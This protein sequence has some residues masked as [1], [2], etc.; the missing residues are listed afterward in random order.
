MFD[1]L[2]SV[3]T[4][5]FRTYISRR[6]ARVGQQRLQRAKADRFSL[7]A[8]QQLALFRQE[9]ERS[10]QPDD[11]EPGVYQIPG[12]KGIW[13]G[14]GTFLGGALDL[15]ARPGQAVSGAVLGAQGREGF[16]TLEGIR[17][18]LFG[19]PEEREDLN[20]ATVLENEGVE[21][22][23]VR[24]IAGLA[25]DMIADPLNV[26]FA[27][28]IRRPFQSAVSA[29]GR[30]VRDAPV[31]V[32]RTVS[33]AFSQRIGGTTHY[34]LRGLVRRGLITQ[35][36]LNELED[37]ARR[38]R[39][40][41]SAQAQESAVTGAKAGIG[42]YTREEG[43]KALQTLMRGHG[44]GRV[45]DAIKAATSLGRPGEARV[46]A[47]FTRRF[48]G[49]KLSKESAERIEGE[50]RQRGE[51]VLERELE[52]LG[53]ASL[54]GLPEGDIARL[55][56]VY[57]NV[58][59][60]PG[61]Y[62]R[63]VWRQTATPQS[64]TALRNIRRTAEK[65]EV[66]KTKGPDL[67]KR[68]EDPEGGLVSDPVELA[69][70]DVYQTTL[71]AER[72]K[73]LRL[74]VN[75]AGS[76]FRKFERKAGAIGPDEGILEI[77]PQ[78]LIDGKELRKAGLAD[79]R[80]P[81]GAQLD[82]RLAKGRT[83]E[84]WV[85]P[86]EM[87][88][89]IDGWIKPKQM[90]G[91]VKLS[92]GFLNMWKPT[93]TVLFPAFFVRNAVGI[94]HNHLMGGVWNPKHYVQALKL[95]RG[96]TDPIVLNGGKARWT[97]EAFQKE[98]ES[99][100]IVGAGSRYVTTAER[101]EEVGPTFFNRIA[102][103]LSGQDIPE[104]L[105]NRFASV[106]S[107]KHLIA[108]NEAGAWRRRGIKGTPVPN[109]FAWG[110]S[111]N[112][113]MDNVGRMAHVLSKMDEGADFATA[114]RSARKYGFAY[115]EAPPTAQGI[116]SAIPFFRWTYFNVPL[117]LE[118]MFLSPH[119]I[120]SKLG[121]VSRSA[122]NL[123][124]DLQPA[125]ESLEAEVATLP[126]W[127]LERHNVVLGREDDGALRVV[128]GFGLPIEDLNKLFA[129]NPGETIQNLAGELAP[130]YRMPLELT[131]NHS[132]FTGEPI[133][134]DDR[135]FSFYRRAWRWIDKVPTPV[136]DKLREWLEFQ[137]VETA[138]GREQFI[139]NPTEMYKL[140]SLMGRIG[141]TFD[142]GWEAVEERDPGLTFNI[143]SGLKVGRVWPKRS[144]RVPL[145]SRLGQDPRLYELYKQYRS[146]PL[147]EG[148]SADEGNTVAT[149]L[150]DI[151]RIRN[152]LQARVPDMPKE[153]AWELAAQQYGSQIDS[154]GEMLVRLVRQLDLPRSGSKVR[155][156][157]KM[158]FPDLVDAVNE[159]DVEMVESLDDVAWDFGER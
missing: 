36:H 154:E 37:G 28:P 149:A 110:T 151:G 109:P 139:A 25:I 61:M 65:G 26:L 51:G 73:L 155:T 93:V 10:L 111:L 60:A 38:Y 97:A 2:G 91:L 63:A 134:D 6:F 85:G 122:Q 131:A 108:R 23:W 71:L 11:Q 140:A 39:H 74:L 50:L 133:R 54:E 69:A 157:F 8:Q 1:P 22:E 45:G 121:Y 147:Y 95:V 153:V 9:Q 126:E 31:P 30:R 5:G 141:M 148:L 83:T 119:G 59:T 105:V 7:R 143:L 90:A 123:A 3:P 70:F 47:Y 14:T 76:P 77:N 135:L 18:G 48:S 67:A 159:L 42:D 129:T 75:R 33:K 12:V 128:Y 58:Q 99:L 68:L 81:A 29:V 16:D 44:K 113:A 120:P 64:Q 62:A 98:A 124:R 103:A 34:E 96:S 79:K 46:L 112:E 144:Q 117:Q 89:I 142:R 130:M 20:F 137:R 136:G 19:T 106:E 100:N 41:S 78:T 21:N 87:V 102:S 150:R 114:A 115:N 52:D 32:L 80:T 24:N 116:G 43:L 94:V 158:H 132:F 35:E 17:R 146:I 104:P 156:A 138:S 4:R 57:L 86:Q 72:E 107:F 101:L 84:E 40:A 13:E 15:L 145:N 53:R 49:T 118:R 55:A 125:A 152:G 127:I 66:R 27:G 88:D 92:D 56:E 82:R